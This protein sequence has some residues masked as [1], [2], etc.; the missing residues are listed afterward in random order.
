MKQTLKAIRTT[1]EVWAKFKALSDEEGRKVGKM[2]EILIE[3]Y[4]EAKDE[5][6]HTSEK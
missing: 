3:N 4:K 6:I 5:S 2:L 1:E